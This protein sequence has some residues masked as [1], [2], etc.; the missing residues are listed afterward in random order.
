M[1]GLLR[2]LLRLRQEHQHLPEERKTNN[3]VRRLARISELKHSEWPSYLISV[4]TIELDRFTL[5]ET[6]TLLTDPLA[7]SK[8]FRRAANRPRFEPKLWETDGL[9]RVQAAADGWPH[10]VVLLA[11]TCVHLVNQQNVPLVS[12]ELFIKVG[13]K[14][15]VSG[16]NVMIQLLK[17]ESE[18]PGEWDYLFGFRDHDALP[19][20][21]D[22]AIRKSLLRRSLV[23]IDNDEVRLRVPLMLQSIRERAELL[24]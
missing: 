7:H 10:L 16:E 23:T 5:A 24:D 8:L 6:S 18:L 17:N 14:A 22:P 1:S 19:L 21:S 11:E 15:V 2:A 3:G 9:R 12:D 20:P 13:R 4:R